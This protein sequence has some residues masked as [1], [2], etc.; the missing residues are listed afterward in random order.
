VARRDEQEYS[1]LM[2]S[3]YVRREDGWKL[4]FHQQTPR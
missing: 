4:V 1:A 3:T 2:S